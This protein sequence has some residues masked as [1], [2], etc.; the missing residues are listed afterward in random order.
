MRISTQN[1]IALVAVLVV[2]FAM[3]S[4][5]V[6]SLSLEGKATTNCTAAGNCNHGRHY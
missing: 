6:A 1:K 4:G 5:V 2:N 3:A